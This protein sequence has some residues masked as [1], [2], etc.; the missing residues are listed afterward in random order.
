MGKVYVQAEKE[1]SEDAVEV[2]LGQV[3][4]EK[5]MQLTAISS[6]QIHPR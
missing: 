1:S 6:T 2:R 5:D 4:W 3:S